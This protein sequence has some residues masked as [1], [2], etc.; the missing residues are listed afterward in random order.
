MEAAPDVAAVDAVATRC[1]AGFPRDAAEAAADAAAVA[2]AVRWVAQAPASAE[3]PAAAHARLDVLT[4]ACRALH[5]LGKHLDAAAATGAAADAVVAATVDLLR[6]GDEARA[7]A[8]A[9]AGDDVGAPAVPPP[10]AAVPR[11]AE[12]VARLTARSVLRRLLAR[13]AG[14]APPA[15]LLR[16]AA[17]AVAADDARGGAAGDAGGCAAGDETAVL[18]LAF[19]VVDATPGVGGPDDA[20]VADAHAALAAAV[21]GWRARLFLRQ[22]GAPAAPDGVPPGAAAYA[23]AA[24]DFNERVDAAATASDG[25]AVDDGGAGGGGAGAADAA[26]AAWRAGEET[27][28][29]APS[30]ERAADAATA[31]ADPD[32]AEAALFALPP[33]VADDDAAGVAALGDAAPCVAPVAWLRAG[34]GGALRHGALPPPPP[35]SASSGSRAAAAG[36]GA[37][38]IPAADAVAVLAAARAAM[39]RRLFAA[40][41]AVRAADDRAAL[42]A[43]RLEA[44]LGAV[45][46]ARRDAPA[47]ETL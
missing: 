2:R 28:H 36:A 3:D 27:A 8:A 12:A 20:A 11:P 6:L 9:A 1:A 39:E 40:S 7:A 24:A 17:D 44:T 23:L 14:R 19:L 41:A 47:A 34:A 32:D 38:L 26:G 13:C 42:L 30:A 33:A 4:A 22:R 45:H 18:P 5:A 10:G 21:R 15:P 43:Q 31:P 35:R 37:A 29:R 46:A 25:A 16:W